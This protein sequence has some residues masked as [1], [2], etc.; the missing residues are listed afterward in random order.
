MSRL[1]QSSA[2]QAGVVLR[3]SS[4][5]IA[6]EQR[7]ATLVK[8]GKCHKQLWNTISLNHLYA[9]SFDRTIRQRVSISWRGFQ[10]A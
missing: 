10:D 9:H 7:F 3:M 2:A 5:H 8:S 6:S 1:R 4:M